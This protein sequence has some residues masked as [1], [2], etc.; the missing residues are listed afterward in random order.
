MSD[1]LLNPPRA[2]RAQLATL[3]RIEAFYG[4]NQTDISFRNQIEERQP[5][6]RVVT[7]DLNDQSEV[8]FDHPSPSL[9]VSLLNACGQVNLLLWRQQW[10][11]ADLSKVNLNARLRI[12]SHAPTSP[13]DRLR[14]HSWI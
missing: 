9:L 8:C 5:E 14:S 7:S 1:R 13:A 11:L 12:V 2:V 3:S 4:L 10:G 6:I